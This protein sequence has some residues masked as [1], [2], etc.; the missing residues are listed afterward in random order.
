MS[1]NCPLIALNISNGTYVIGKTISIIN[2]VNVCLYQTLWVLTV[3][4]KTR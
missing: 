2:H 4:T 1:L 3:K